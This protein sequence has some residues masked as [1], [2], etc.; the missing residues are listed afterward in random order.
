MFIS[1]QA[2]I[3][4]CAAIL[5]QER[6]SCEA[7]GFDGFL[8]GFGQAG[9]LIQVLHQRFFPAQPADKFIHAEIHCLPGNVNLFQP[10]F[11]A[12]CRNFPAISLSMQICIIS[13][14]LITACKMYHAITQL[15]GYSD[16]CFLRPTDQRS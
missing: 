5:G 13:V 7:R 1:K 8:F 4:A 3:P 9:E 6:I 2:K 12:V 14:L 15:H 16:G 10:G 11:G